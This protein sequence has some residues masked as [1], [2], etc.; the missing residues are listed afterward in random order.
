MPPSGLSF[1]GGRSPRWKFLPKKLAAHFINVEIASPPL[2]ATTSISATVVVTN[3]LTLT[4]PMPELQMTGSAEAYDFDDL[5][6]VVGSLSL[7]LNPPSLLM[8]G[9]VEAMGSLLLE[10]PVPALIMT[11]D[12]F[13]AARY[14][15]GLVMN[16]SHFAVS[17]Y[18]G[19]DF[20]SLAYFNGKFLGANSQ[21][22][23]S[24]GGNKDNGLNIN[25]RAKMPVLD[26]YQGILKKARDVWLTCRTDG[27]MMLVIQIGEEDYYD[28]LFEATGRAQEYRCKL[29]KGIDERFLAFELRNVDGSDFDTNNLRF[30]TDGLVTRRKR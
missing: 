30:T 3:S 27:Q 26:S 10:M 21:G 24:F 7:E 29:P 19:Y 8:T 11:G 4:M 17:D 1:P 5:S 13:F 18:I 2:Q 15:K 28:D 14:I 12:Q 22:I 9:F 25:A 16:M 20:N 23:F 6:G